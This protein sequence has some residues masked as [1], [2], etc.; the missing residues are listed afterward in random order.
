MLKHRVLHHQ[1]KETP[2]IMKAISYHRSALSRQAAEA[3]R[4]RRRGGEGSILNSKAEF[5]RSY[6][7]RLA[8]VEEETLKELDRQEEE[9]ERVTQKEIDDNHEVWESRKVTRRS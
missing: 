5:N 9:L 8:L 6:V 4:I 3:V 7:P 1:D 2:F